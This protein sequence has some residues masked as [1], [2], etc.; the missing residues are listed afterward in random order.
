MLPI[1]IALGVAI[2]YYLWLVGYFTTATALINLILAAAF[3]VFVLLY[4]VIP[5]WRARIKEDKI[6]TDRVKEY[7]EYLKKQ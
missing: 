1:T 7:I 3:G 4:N 5:L 2:L 6:E